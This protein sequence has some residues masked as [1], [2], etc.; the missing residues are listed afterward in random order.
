MGYYDE[1]EGKKP[2]IAIKA[3]VKVAKIGIVEIAL[4]ICFML[5]TISVLTFLLAQFII[6][7]SKPPIITPAMG[8]VSSYS[9]GAY[10]TGQC[11][12][13]REYRWYDNE[14]YE[15]RCT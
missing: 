13:W 9:W 6:W 15:Q 10:D 11:R 8:S 12:H 1:A 3:E 7:L 5:A 2:W 14:E 4:T